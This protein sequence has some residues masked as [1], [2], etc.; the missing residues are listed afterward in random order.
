MKCN[1]SAP[2][3]SGLLP[4]PQRQS[5]YIQL[6]CTVTGQITHQ[7]SVKKIWPAAQFV[8]ISFAYGAIFSSRNL[9]C[10]AFFFIIFFCYMPDFYETKCLVIFI[11]MGKTKVLWAGQ[12]SINQLINVLPA[13][14][15]VSQK[16]RRT[17]RRTGRRGSRRRQ[18][19]HRRLGG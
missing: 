14:P 5:L 8:A 9:A 10:G 17:H 7:D 2:S 11:T 16:D 4:S 19:S 13:A 1:W 3:P 18:R 12:R 15:F 6:F